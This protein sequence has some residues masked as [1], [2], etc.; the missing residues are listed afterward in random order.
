MIER[1]LVFAKEPLIGAVKTRLAA[2]IGLRHACGIYRAMLFDLF[3]NISSLEDVLAIYVDR[4]AKNSFLRT[5]SHRSIRAQNGADLGE[6]M[7]NAFVE[8]FRT[9]AQKA[10]LIGSDIPQISSS[11]I[12]GYFSA[13]SRHSMVIGPAADGG[14]YLIGFQR[15]DFT[16]VL[17]ENIS[18]STDQVFPQTIAKCE[19]AGLSCYTGHVLHDIDT[20]KDLQ[21]VLLRK[22]M[23]SL[24]PHVA[25]YI[26]DHKLLP[27]F[28]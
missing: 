14:Y 7:A 10:I 22:E 27:G 12:G 20:L 11:L 2:D 3:A 5:V 9:D 6:K 17:F 16:S 28:F 1:L 15:C 18:W 26:T 8:V 23:Q 19:R 4:P 13:L 24:L 21:A 25:A